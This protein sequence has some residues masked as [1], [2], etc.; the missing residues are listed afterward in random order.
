MNAETPYPPLSGCEKVTNDTITLG[1]LFCFS[2]LFLF[3]FFEKGTTRVDLKV[4]KQFQ[5][6]YTITGTSPCSLGNIRKDILYNC[7][8]TYFYFLKN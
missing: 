8:S 2:F 5:F 3:F 6:R 4:F 1:T 7:L